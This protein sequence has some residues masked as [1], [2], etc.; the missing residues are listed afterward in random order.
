MPDTTQ[1]RTELMSTGITRRT[2]LKAGGALVISV[3]APQL[4]RAAQTMSVRVW[5]ADEYTRITLEN[6]T[7]LK[8]THFILK[9]PERL[10][11]DIEGIDLNAPLRDLV[12]KIL[13]GDPYVKQVRVGQHRPHVVRLVF[14]LKEAIKP[15][16]FAPQ[17][18]GRI[19]PSP[20]T[21]SLSG[22][23]PTIR[24]PP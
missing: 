22:Q 24:L 6:S 23:P 3:I 4:A 9:N 7:P 11:V 17:T 13:P 14:D 21:R 16:V 12:A 10:V 15:Q 5:P 8:A 1:F 19:S 2:V 20:A 18:C